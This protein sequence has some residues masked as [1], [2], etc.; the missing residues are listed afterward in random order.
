MRLVGWE[1][2]NQ[3]VSAPR[4]T[5]GGAHSDAKPARFHFI[6]ERPNSAYH[7]ERSSGDG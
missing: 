2:E 1:R 3:T 5:G 4:C 7:P 6:P